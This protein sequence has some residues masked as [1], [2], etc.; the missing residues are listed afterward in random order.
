[1][2]EQDDVR[3]FHEKFKLDLAK[4]PSL[5]CEELFRFRLKFMQE[6]LDEFAEAHEDGHLINAAD[7]LIDLA[8]VLHGTALLMALPWQKLWDNVHTQNMKKVRISRTEIDGSKRKSRYDIIKPAGWTPPDHT[9][10]L[11]NRSWWPVFD[12]EDK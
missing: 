10:I 9:V 6:E 2:N 8:Y 12:P 4:E 11:G 1:M 5:L 7:G 3:Q